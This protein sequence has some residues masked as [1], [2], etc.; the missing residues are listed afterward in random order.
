[1]KLE[2]PNR[3]LLGCAGRVGLAGNTLL[4]T[5]TSSPRP[6]LRVGDRSFVV[7]VEVRSWDHEDMFGYSEE[8]TLGLSGGPPWT[9]AGRVTQYVEVVS[10]VT[11]VQHRRA[12][13]RDL[14]ADGKTELCV[15]EVLEAGVSPSTKPARSPWHPLARVRRVTAWRATSAAPGLTRARSLDASCPSLG[16]RPFIATNV[17][18]GVFELDPVFRRRPAPGLALAACPRAPRLEPRWC[19]CALQEES[20]SLEMVSSA[21]DSRAP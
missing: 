16:Y 17:G 7:G 9:V 5:C 6:L 18:Y 20:C 19:R 10:P 14:D 3:E 12:L 21:L 1:M 11:R 4:R 13:T 15:E 2:A 8:V